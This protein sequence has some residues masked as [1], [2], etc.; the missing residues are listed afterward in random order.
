M[1]SHLPLEKS[2]FVLPPRLPL[3]LSL[4]LSLVLLYGCAT[5]PTAP[6]TAPNAAD[7]QIQ[8]PRPSPRRR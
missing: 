4:S 5:A 7:T 3:Q 6:A 2:F 8:Q 1:V